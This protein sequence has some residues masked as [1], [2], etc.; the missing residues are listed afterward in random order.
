M[1]KNGEKKDFFSGESMDHTPIFYNASFWMEN[2]LVSTPNPLL[3]LLQSW[4]DLI[5]ELVLSTELRR[6]TFCFQNIFTFTSFNKI[7]TT[8]FFFFLTK[9]DMRCLH[10]YTRICAISYSPFVPREKDNEILCEHLFW[11]LWRLWMIISRVTGN[12]TFIEKR[13]T[14]F[15]KF[16]CIF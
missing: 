6:L 13:L 10:T 12:A 7:F 8:F 16:G 2:I 11:Y 14:I 4:F 5:L 3:I 1:P 15:L 9:F